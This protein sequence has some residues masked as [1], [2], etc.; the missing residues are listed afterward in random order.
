MKRS[1]RL[2]GGNTVYQ[3]Q[4]I[5]GTLT[6]MTTK[7]LKPFRFPIHGSIDGWS[8]KI[9]WLQLERSNN[10]P[11]VPAKHFLQCVAELGGCPVKVRSDCGTENGVLAAI[12]CEFRGSAD[13]HVFGSSP[14]N[15]RIEGWWFF[16]QG[17]VLPDGSTLRGR[18]FMV[19][20]LWSCTEGSCFGEGT[21]EHSSY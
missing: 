15:Q 6:V 2:K 10:N 20:F 21:L 18:S 7:L 3:V 9:M 19:L 14:A 16:Y 12:Q 1:K 5:V 17:T 13:A 11:E 8:R 4:I